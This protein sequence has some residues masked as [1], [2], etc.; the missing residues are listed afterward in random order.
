MKVR[1][2]RQ[3]GVSRSNRCV[4][5]SMTNF[6][7]IAMPQTSQKRSP[8]AVMGQ[9]IPVAATN[10][11]DVAPVQ[12][13]GRTDADYSNNRWALVNESGRQ[14]SGCEGCNGRQCMEYS[15]TV[16]STFQVATTVTLPTMSEY[17]G[18]SSC[19]R[20]RIQDAITNTLSPHE[21]QHVAA[22]RTYNG[23]VDTPLTMVGCRSDLQDR[24]ASRATEIHN[25]VE[26]PRRA[27]AQAASNALDP[28]VVN[29]DL[30]CT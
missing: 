5:S 25:G 8:K 19:Q 26:G 30:N 18:Y 21:Q 12:L 27:S 9:A 24:V 16:R 7:K 20:Q 1:A 4:S 2:N 6:F 10:F 11:G 29:V 3:I 13:R 14:G 22:F 17:A 15:A 28:F 23:S